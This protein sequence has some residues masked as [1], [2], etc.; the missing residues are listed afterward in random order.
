MPLSRFFRV[1]IR[2]VHRVALLLAFMSLLNSFFGLFRDRLLASAFGASRSLDIYYA[3]FRIPDLIFTLSLFVVASTAFIPL[4][5]ERLGGSRQEADEF[6]DSVVSVFLFGIGIIGIVAYIFMPSLIL[7]VAPGFSSAEQAIV[8]RLSRMLLLSPLFLGMSNIF[9]AVVQAS[10]RFLSYAVAPIFYNLGIIVGVLL[11]LPR[12]GM[13]GII[14]GVVL[15]AFAHMAIQI[16]TLA[17]LGKLPR[18]RFRISRDV[19]R[20]VR[21]S[22]P[23]ACALSLNQ[24]TILILTALASLLAAG[25]IAIFNLSLNLYAL[26]LTIIGLSYSIAAF[27]TMAELAL[28]KDKKVFF[29]H[30]TSATRFILFWTLPITGLFLIFRA[31]IVRLVLG[32]GAFAW[33]DTHLTIA[34]LLLFS[35]A[36]VTQSLVTLFVRAYYALGRAREPILY[37]AIASII[38]IFIAITGVVL[39]EKSVFVAR[40]FGFLLRIRMQTNISDIVFLSLPFAYSIGAFANALLLGFGLLRLNGREAFFQLLRAV[41]PIMLVTILMSLAGFGALKMIGPYF[42]LTSFL[43]V[44]M[45]AALAGLVAVVV[46]VV[47]F[48]MLGVREFRE[49]KEAL[50]AKVKERSVDIVQPETEHL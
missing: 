19:M 29:E 11:L 33:V 28:K 5:L 7:F 12:F 4:F 14:A 46:G 31:H 38:T 36:I 2:G 48:E 21:Y 44:L 41:A 26:P 34:S 27:P 25:D 50:F 18:I 10:R 15:G 37:N 9:S 6:F 17:R 40:L 43:G 32:A 20:L 24:I 47:L 23:R 13:I 30:L 16:P 49:L 3:A 8:V 42:Q 1:E 35:L 22:F 39:V 45:E